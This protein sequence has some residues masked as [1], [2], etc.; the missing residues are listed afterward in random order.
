MLR[1]RGSEPGKVEIDG[2]LARKGVVFLPLSQAA[3]EHP[4]LVEK[5]LFKA[6]DPDFFLAVRSAC[7][8]R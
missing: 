7:L 2:E 1:Q 5:H 8:N 4:E 6:I 3:K